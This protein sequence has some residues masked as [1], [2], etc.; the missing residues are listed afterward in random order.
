MKLLGWCLVAVPAVY[1]LAL[2]VILTHHFVVAG[3]GGQVWVFGA[4]TFFIV[5]ALCACSL[6]VGVLVSRKR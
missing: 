3:E 2:A 4:S 1:F 5:T 6:I